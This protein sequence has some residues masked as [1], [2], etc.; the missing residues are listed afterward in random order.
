MRLLGAEV[1][2]SSRYKKV[3]KKISAAAKRL[4]RSAR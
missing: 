2:D 3:E 1:A 4:A